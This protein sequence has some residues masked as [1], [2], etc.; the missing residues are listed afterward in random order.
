MI[1]RIGFFFFYTYLVQTTDTP[2]TIREKIVKIMITYNKKTIG[3]CVWG[4]RVLFIIRVYT[5]NSPFWCARR[6][7][8][9][10]IITRRRVSAAERR[11]FGRRPIWKRSIRRDFRPTNN[12]FSSVYSR[13]SSAGLPSGAEWSGVEWSRVAR[14]RPPGVIIRD[15]RPRQIGQTS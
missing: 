7:W 6:P 14:A 15:A 10:I 1:I 11:V 2:E 8:G 4:G 12:K 9:N 3:M 5:R 13:V